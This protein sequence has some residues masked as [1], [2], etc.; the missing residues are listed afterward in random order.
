MA[1]AVFGTV[2]TRTHAEEVVSRCAK[3]AFP[4]VIFRY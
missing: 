2:A 1:Y 4:I 3:P